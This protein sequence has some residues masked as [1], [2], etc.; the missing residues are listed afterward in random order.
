V[1]LLNFT[2]D[3]VRTRAAFVLGIL[4]CT[5]L[6]LGTSNDLSAASKARAE[7]AFRLLQSDY[8]AVNAYSS[9]DGRITRIYGRAF[10]SGSSPED[11]AEK[12]R[13]AHSAVLGAEASDL[14]PVSRLADGRH[15]QP[16]MYNSQT[17][18]SKFTLVYYSQFR[19]GLP[20]F[21]AD[22]RLLVRNEPGYP[23]VL[24]ASALRDLGDF[25]AANRSGINIGTSR[26]IVSIEHP[27]LTEFTEP[28]EV[29]WAGYDDISSEPIHAFVFEGLNDNAERWLF[30][31][32]AG[33]GEILYEEDR[34]IFEDVP[35]NV[36]GLATEGSGAEHCEDEILM[37]MPYAE[38]NIGAS[39]KYAD[40]YGDFLFKEVLASPVTVGS[41]MTGE[42]FTIFN[43]LGSVEDL[44]QIVTPPD[45]ANFIHNASNT[46]YIR[47]QVNAY[48]QS[49]IVRD[50]TLQH[51]SL[52]PAVSTQT[53][54]P[55]YVNRT[56]GYCPG[57]AWYDPGDESL[58]FC[59]TGSTYPNTAWA[60]VI[61]HEYGHHLVNMAGSGQGQYGEGMGDV[62]GLLITDESG[63]GFGFFGDCFTPL[64]DADNTKQY[65][66]SGAIHDCGQLMSGCVWDTRNELMVTYPGGEYLDTL[67]NLAINAMLLHTGDLITPQITI[68][69]LT[70][71][72]DDAN[73]DNGTP[74]REEICTGFG[75]HNMDCP[76]LAYVSFDYPSGQPEIVNPNQT[77]T[78]PVNVNAVAGTP[79]QGSGAMFYSIDGGFFLPGVMN[80]VS[81]NQYEAVLPATDCGSI[82]SWYVTVETLEGGT[83]SDPPDAPT[84]SF[85]AV[86]ATGSA[87][88]FGDNF[89]TDQGWTVSSSAVDG[90]WQRGDPVGGGDRGDPP[91][92]YDG[93]G[94]CYLTDNV[95]GNSDVDDGSTTLYS[96]IL[97][98]EGINA[99]IGYARWYSNHAGDSPYADEMTID[100]SS[101]G[102]GS[103]T[104]VEIVGPV[105]QASGGWYES[106][107]WVSAYV[108]PSVNIQVRFV[109]S[110][111]GAG[112]VVEAG[113]DAFE[114][115]A[116]DCEITYICGDA[117][118]SLAVDIDDAVY[119][120]Q[121]IFAGGS[122][123]DPLESG[124]A[125]CI[126]AVDIDDAVFLITYIFSQG[127]EPCST[128]P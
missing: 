45:P 25:S 96:P 103:W 93:S 47:S 4:L 54:F 92:D 128:C 5:V 11:A 40:I 6:F 41:P 38:V 62:M 51:N 19:D 3:R 32:D 12:F 76:A 7:A 106:G 126:G 119:L 73:I 74:H 114:V 118:G 101:D 36:S 85:S 91:N 105:D 13:V 67:A 26:N 88:F 58:N 69:W 64:R 102:G 8:P 115:V 37:A 28:Q 120:I 24:A 56:D 20:V 109:A 123:P 75:A 72:D 95:D 107:F 44:T 65:P 84:S 16:V 63:T 83:A 125:D 112:S 124:D 122:P 22:V 98:L 18:E 33:T 48:I 34:I 81:P 49:N 87:V 127:P 17:G 104:N 113:L 117:D 9:D 97:N 111:L 66:C 43:Y 121:Y 110:D 94:M 27:T 29:I 89:Q 50:L 82:I 108:T 10:G 68:D 99:R 70:L 1:E 15:T 35:G 2:G 46:E 14:L 100:V 79:V 23:V 30:V 55:V 80:E 59:A 60:T 77:E 71:D 57:N 21:R 78:I 116:Y 86:A 42:F 90:Q 31:A 61:H 53:G 52:Y 39:M